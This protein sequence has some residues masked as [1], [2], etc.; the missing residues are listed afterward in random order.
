MM[1][2][3]LP[4]TLSNDIGVFPS[5]VV[6]PKHPK[7]NIFTRKTPWLLGKPNILGNPHIDDQYSSSL[8]TAR[9]NATLWT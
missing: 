1:E 8:E 2:Q 6:P 9:F 4:E 7:M 5:M 3:K